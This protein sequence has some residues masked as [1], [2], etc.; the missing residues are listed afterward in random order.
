VTTRS[1]GSP[2]SG[3]GSARPLRTRSSGGGDNE[4]GG[5]HDD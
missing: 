1:S 4:G 5:G 2:G 3:A